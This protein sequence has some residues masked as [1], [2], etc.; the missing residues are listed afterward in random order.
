MQNRAYWAYQSAT[1]RSTLGRLAVAL[2]LGGLLAVPAQAGA[3]GSGRGLSVREARV[4]IH[5]DERAA[6]R[7]DYID[8]YRIDRC[9][10]RSRRAVRCHVTEWS[11]EGPLTLIYDG[12]ET[13]VLRG[14]RVRIIY[15]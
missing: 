9:Y 3:S 5:R 1:R 13:V 15:R 6:L 2:A 12:W 4:V 10:R 7:A 11:F 8:R 14:A